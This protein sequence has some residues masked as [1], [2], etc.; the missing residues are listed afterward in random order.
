MMTARYKLTRLGYSLYRPTGSKLWWFFKNDD[1]WVLIGYGSSDL[2]DMESEDFIIGYQ[3]NVT[4]WN[5]V[6]KPKD[7][8]PVRY[9]RTASRN[10]KILD[11]NIGLAP[12]FGNKQQG[13]VINLFMR[14]Y[15]YEWYKAAVKVFETNG[16][17]VKSRNLE[18]TDK[19]K[20]PKKLKKPRVS[21]GGIRKVKLKQGLSPAPVKALGFAPS[22]I[23]GTSE[24]DSLFV[25]G[26]EDGRTPSS[27]PKGALEPETACDPI[28]IFDR[29]GVP[30]SPD[31]DQL[32]PF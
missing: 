28:S 19:P 22:R 12:A 26:D 9:T 17:V 14:E 27:S 4:S 23:T 30:N 1:I 13:M 15:Y 24:S 10:T 6:I 8:N 2:S 11:A 18:N 31:K 16:F 29:A 5:A 32:C 7:K 25:S 20:K 3:V 21:K